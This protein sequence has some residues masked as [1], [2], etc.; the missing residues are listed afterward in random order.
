MHE[1]TS[2]PS[3]RGL[4]KGAVA[5]TA[6]AANFAPSFAAEQCDAELMAMGRELEALRTRERAMYAE[7]E[8]LAAI[9]TQIRP[10]PSPALLAYHGEGKPLFRR[11]DTGAW[12]TDH[13][14]L[15]Q[16]RDHAHAWRVT[17]FC[18]G[19]CHEA[20]LLDHLEKWREA[21]HQ[22]RHVSGASAAAQVWEKASEA[23]HE[24]CKR[25]VITPATTAGGIRVKLT[26]LHDCCGDDVAE[27]W[28][29]AVIS[30][31]GY[32]ADERMVFSVFRDALAILGV[33]GAHV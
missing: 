2:L 21:G 4:L 18:E 25:I 30:G 12:I 33:G 22:A 5:A 8:R 11:T 7:E 16:I 24:L 20:E 1:R 28:I 9:A 15:A 19:E 6:A 26:A 23:C 31:P 14:V 27:E 17:G 10:P 13:K 29:A 32:T 3:R